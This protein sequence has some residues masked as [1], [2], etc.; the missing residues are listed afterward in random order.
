MSRTPSHHSSRR[1][2]RRAAT[3]ARYT[4]RMAVLHHELQLSTNGHGQVV[5]VECDRRARQRRVVLSFVG[6]REGG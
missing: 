1:R 2:P 6:E 4:R 3:E 5:L